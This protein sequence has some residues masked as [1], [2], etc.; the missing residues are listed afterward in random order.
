MLIG[1][2]K[3]R[4]L[5]PLAL[6]LLYSVGFSDASMMLLDK[7]SSY[8]LDKTLDFPCKGHGCGCKTA[9]KCLINCCCDKTSEKN[10]VNLYICR[11]DQTPEKKAQESCCSTDPEHSDSCCTSETDEKETSSDVIALASCAIKSGSCGFGFDEALFKQ[12]RPQILEF[13]YLEIYKGTSELNVYEQRSE[14]FSFQEVVF[15][16]TKVPIA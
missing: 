13:N 7:A 2:N 10:V 11:P 6:V 3:F 14:N 12:Q 4:K 9:L 15:P 8:V 16:R 5:L 1:L